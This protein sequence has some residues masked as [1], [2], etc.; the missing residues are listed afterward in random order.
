MFVVPR[1]VL[2]EQY[3]ERPEKDESLDVDPDID[4]YDVVDDA[5]REGSVHSAPPATGVAKSGD[6]NSSSTPSESPPR[7]HTA[8]PGPRGK[9]HE[10]CKHLDVQIDEIFCRF[11][12][13]AEVS[14][15][16]QCNSI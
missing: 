15:F 6:N 7:H 11:K 16:V 1:S 10:G 12:F 9:S 2:R 5:L 4:T 14:I 13:F 8:D 3:E